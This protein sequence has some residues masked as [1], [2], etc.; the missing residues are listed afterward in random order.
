MGEVLSTRHRAVTATVGDH[1]RA[2]APPV[3]CAPAGWAGPSSR[4]GG[5]EHG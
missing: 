2:H 4:W 3:P 1:R 5:R